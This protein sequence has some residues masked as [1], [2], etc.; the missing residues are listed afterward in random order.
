[1]DIW[2]TGF[3]RPVWRQPGR[4][5]RYHAM[6]SRITHCAICAFISQPGEEARSRWLASCYVTLREIHAVRMDCHNVIRKYVGYLHN[7]VATSETSDNWAKVN[8]LQYSMSTIWGNYSCWQIIMGKCFRNF[9][10]TKILNRKNVQLT[11]GWFG[12]ETQ[13]RWAS[14]SLRSRSRS[15]PPPSSR[16]RTHYRASW[17]DHRTVDRSLMRPAASNILEN[18]HSNPTMVNTY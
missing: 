9:G 2:P 13:L 11:V 6:Q 5:F 16:W 17:L 1:M 12:S 15:S 7:N 3:I 18:V 4:W 10:I 8:S 14:F